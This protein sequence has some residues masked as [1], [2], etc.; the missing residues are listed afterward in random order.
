MDYFHKPYIR[1]TVYFLT[2]FHGD[3]YRGLNAQWKTGLI[4]CSPI[5]GELLKSILNIDARYI[6]KL[7][8]NIRHVINGVGVQLVDANHCPGAVM[9]LFDYDG[10]YVL[11][12]GDFRYH[13]KMKEYPAFIHTKIERVYLDTTYCN[14]N[15]TFPSQEES[16]SEVVTIIAQRLQE[17]KQKQEEASLSFESS[18]RRT[19]FLLSAYRIG[20]ER[21]FLTAGKECFLTLYADAYKR[22]ILQCLEL[23]EM[24][25]NL[26]SEDPREAN[27][28][29]LSMDKLGSMFPFF[30]P[31]FKK[32]QSYI[33]SHRLQEN[34]SHVIGFI[35][36]GWANGSQWNREHKRSLKIK[37]FTLK[38]FCKDTFEINLIPYSEHSNNQELQ[39]FI[40]F[41]DPR[42]IIPTVYGNEKEFKKMK[43]LFYPFQKQHSLMYSSIFTKEASLLKSSQISQTPQRVK[44]PPSKAENAEE[45]SKANNEKLWLLSSKLFIDLE[46]EE[47][48][49]FSTSPSVYSKSTMETLNSPSH[50]SPTSKRSKSNKFP[51]NTPSKGQKQRSLLEFLSP[52]MKKEKICPPPPPLLSPLSPPSILKEDVEI[53]HGFHACRDMDSPLSSQSFIQLYPSET[54][55]SSC[56]DKVDL[57][58]AKTVENIKEKEE[59]QSKIVDLRSQ[60]WD[61]QRRLA[62]EAVNLQF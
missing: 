13:P 27:L 62:F 42:L 39:E 17:E 49:S 2:H 37:K 16:I 44:P 50:F 22:S 59:N 60:K 32:I 43:C 18:S 58:S 9:L 7:E 52:C 10:K 56:V 38:R 14:A 35:P 12:T 19:L 34:F 25:K 5:T 26:F 21:M 29:I 57:F 48:T 1:K 11:H 55:S 3:H 23:S 46:E 31:N 15:F 45:A 51:S 33:T 40:K 41:L 47:G 24:E 6:H 61:L 28:H 30:R 54:S 36:T 8:L 53:S 4:Y 20:K